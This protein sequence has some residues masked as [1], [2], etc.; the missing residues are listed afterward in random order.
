CRVLRRSTGPAGRRKSAS[1][2][3]G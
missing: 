1:P 2:D 3:A